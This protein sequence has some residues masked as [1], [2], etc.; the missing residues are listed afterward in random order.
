MCTVRLYLIK[1]IEM[2]CKISTSPSEYFTRFSR[3]SWRPSRNA[4]PIKF[5]LRCDKHFFLLREADK[6]KLTN[7]ELILGYS[8]ILWLNLGWGAAKYSWLTHKASRCLQPKG[9]LLDQN[10][11]GWITIHMLSSVPKMWLGLWHGLLP[12]SL[13]NTVT[14]KQHSRVTWHWL[15]YSPRSTVLQFLEVLSNTSTRLEL[16]WIEHNLLQ[17]QGE[18]RH[19]YR[20]ILSG[21]W[22]RSLQNCGGFTAT[23]LHM[24]QEP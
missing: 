7:K 23:A 24:N 18:E 8:L 5:V 17:G 15:S 22:S 11:T 14:L 9:Y 3:G 2:H 1:S 20:S 19:I 16:V 12:R 13:N 21:F 10:L 6:E 4:S